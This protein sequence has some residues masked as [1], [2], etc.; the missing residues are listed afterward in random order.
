M[1]K[2]GLKLFSKFT[3]LY[4]EA[5]VPD[6][7]KE[8]FEKLYGVSTSDNPN[9]KD[10][11]NDKHRKNPDNDWGIEYRVYFDGPDWITI[12]LKVLGYHV[13]END[14]LIAVDF[15]RLHPNH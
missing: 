12:S 7:Y 8:R 6:K 14:N 2:N 3:R 13:E 1:Q 9:G 11:Y 5:E 15:N 10:G 4:L